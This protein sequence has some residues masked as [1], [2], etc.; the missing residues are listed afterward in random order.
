MDLIEARN[1]DCGYGKKPIFSGISFTVRPGEVFCVLG[2]NGVGKTTLFRTILGFEKP[3]GG[4][5]F[6][7]TKRLRYWKRNDLA[8]KIAY[9]PQA[10][11]PPFPYTVEEVVIMGRT[12]RFEKSHFGRNL[13]GK[14][15]YEKTE[16]ILEHMGIVHLRKR[17]YTHI[18]GG[19]R[20]L[21]LIAR[22]LAQEPEY[23]VMDEP[24]LNLDFGNQM[25]LIN[26]TIRLRETG[27]GIIMTSHH[28]DHVFLCADRVMLMKWGNRFSIGSKDEILTEEQL[29]D[30]YEV[31]IKILRG[32]RDNGSTVAACT[33]DLSFSP[34]QRKNF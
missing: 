20:Q 17:T 5:I 11:I 27:M 10:H 22:A 28:P 31:S 8:K 24:A 16:N 12:I 1:L 15:D 18:S 30:T 14:M 33:A 21:V 7:E 3:L 13:P 2:P 23:L 32:N 34:K 4:D 9:V 26:E 25:H 19:E 29:T 6:L